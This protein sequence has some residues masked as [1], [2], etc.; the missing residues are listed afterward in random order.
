[1]L[2]IG[3]QKNWQLLKKLAELDK[4]P[5]A[6][7]FSGQEKLGKRTLA[8]EF[9][10]WLLKEDIGKRQ[11]PDFIF[12]EPE[13]KE[14]KISQI[15]ELIWKL[16]LKPS[17][18]PFKVAIID[19][20]HCL[21]QEAQ[22]SLLKTL[23]EPRGKALLILITE[24]P[25]TLLPTILSRLQKI[26]F[27]PVKKTEIE[28]YLQKNGVGEKESEEIIRFSLGKPGQVMDFI[29]NPQKLKAQKKTVSDFIKVSNSNLNSR[30]RYVKDLSAAPQDLNPVR[31]YKIKKE[32]QREQISNGVKETLDTW[33]GH[34]RDILVSG[35]LPPKYS[36]D[37]L[38]DIINL[39]Q[40]TNFLL[41]TT[42]VNPRL[43]L[44]ILMLEL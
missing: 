1:M 7:L 14:I 28:D 18:A 32:P 40:K 34:L 10:K 2:I 25:E 22:S 13:E 24:Y 31:D 39:I 36:F 3:H 42:N 19:Q 44:E 30:F 6:L 17:V 20:A 15:R 21:N 29:S 37:K 12:I 26:K 23:E 5:H 4:L 43:A 16:S 38:K 33:T 8:T 9:V 27:Y 11:H 41:S 35:I